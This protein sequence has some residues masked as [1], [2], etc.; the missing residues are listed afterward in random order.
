M[1]ISLSRRPA[2]TSSITSIS[3]DVSVGCVA[4]PGA[5]PERPQAAAAGRRALRERC[6]AGRRRVCCGCQKVDLP[7]SANPTGDLTAVHRHFS[8]SYRSAEPDVVAEVVLAQVDSMSGGGATVATY[9]RSGRLTCCGASRAVAVV[10][11]S[12]RSSASSRR[13]DARSG[14]AAFVAMMKATDFRD[15]HDGAVFRRGDRTR[16]RR[17]LCSATNA[18]A[19]AHG[20]NNSGSSA[21]A[22]LLH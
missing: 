15:R 12:R 11:D 19:T 10:V 20:T 4:V 1:A 21:G 8:L 7:E 3:R 22:D 18:F 16:D 13:R 6:A 9:G 14:R 2:A 17:N 5:W